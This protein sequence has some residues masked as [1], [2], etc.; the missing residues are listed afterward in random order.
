MKKANI[1]ASNIDLSVLHLSALHKRSGQFLSTLTAPKD[2]YLRLTL[3]N[4]FDALAP[5]M[6]EVSAET[7]AYAMRHGRRRSFLLFCEG[8]CVGWAHFH[9]KEVGYKVEVKVEDTE[10]VY[11]KAKS[12]KAAM[13][14]AKEEATQRHESATAVSAERGEP[15]VMNL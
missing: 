2:K 5:N 8:R 9:R 7:S 1:N 15:E 14:K 13:A 4:H 11:V 3:A 10:I 12:A 6:D